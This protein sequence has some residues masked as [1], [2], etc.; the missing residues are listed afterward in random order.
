MRKRVITVGVFIGMLML[1]P[2]FGSQSIAKV[3]ENDVS[4]ITHEAT[5][6]SQYLNFNGG[7]GYGD[8]VRVTTRAAPGSELFHTWRDVSFPESLNSAQMADLDGD[9]HLDMAVGG[10]T[11]DQNNFEGVVRVC[12][13]NGDGTFQSAVG[14]RFPEVPTQVSF[15]ALGDLDGDGDIDIAAIT[16]KSW[17]R[18]L[19]VLLNNGDGTFKNG[20][21]HYAGSKP[22]FAGGG[23][24]MG[25]FDGDGDLDTVTTS[26]T[27]YYDSSN[28]SVLINTGHGNFQS[29]VNYK[30]EDFPDSLALSDLDGDGDLDVAVACSDGTISVHMN[31]GDGTLQDAA[32]YQAGSGDQSLA[33]GDVD[34]DGDPDAVVANIGSVSVLINNG[35]GNFQIPVVYP[36][37]NTGGAGEG[38]SVM[39]GDLD[40]DGDLDLAGTFDRW[41][42]DSDYIY[43][44]LNK[45]EGT[46]QY[47]TSYRVGVDAEAVALGDLDGDGSIDIATLTWDSANVPVLLGHGDGTFQDPAYYGVGGRQPPALAIGDVDGDGDLDLAVPYHTSALIGQISVLLN[48][49]IQGDTHTIRATA[50]SGGSVTPAGTVIAMNGADQKFTIS[51]DDGYHR[52]SRSV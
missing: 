49:S 23:L 36:N 26:H 52:F 35:Y 12:L 29:T 19:S 51:P 32:T 20:E 46:F 41:Y 9:G 45:G 18:K 39:L 28:I 11:N 15:M 33:L 5:V 13:G 1:S 3:I 7:T 17:D 48:Q 34:G 30:T 25:D 38:L 10:Y 44:L 2:V 14:Y 6:R 16:D 8:D 47:A 4:I 37:E 43:V 27:G 31:N 40:G 50:G 24:V 21:S 22:N 42:G